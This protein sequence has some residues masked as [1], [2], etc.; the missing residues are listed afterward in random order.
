LEAAEACAAGAFA[1]SAGAFA[2]S[3]AFFAAKAAW[4]DLHSGLAAA[5][6]QSA[7]WAKAGLTFRLPGC[8]I[9]G[10]DLVQIDLDEEIVG[11]HGPDAD[12]QKANECQK[13]LHGNLRAEISSIYQQDLFS[14]AAAEIATGIPRCV[15]F[16]KYST[17]VLEIQS[18]FTARSG[19]IPVD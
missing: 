12:E 7:A 6:L 14:R 3:A 19:I 1:E 16:D 2:E 18:A 15:S 13:T 17:R 11:R 5:R 10:I 9:G 4:T 8:F